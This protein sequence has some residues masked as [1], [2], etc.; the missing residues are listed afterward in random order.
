MNKYLTCTTTIRR[1][2]E[3]D[4]PAVLAIWEDGR[5]ALAEAGVDQWADGYPNEEILREDIAAGQSY[6]V[7]VSRTPAAVATIRPEADIDYEEIAEGTWLSQKKYCA[8]H[9]IATC[10][11]MKRMGL[12]SFIMENAAR[13]ARENGCVSLRI[14][15][16][17]DN[18][19]MQAFLERN[20]FV[21]CGRIRLH[22][23]GKMRVAFEKLL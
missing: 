5:R 21:R 19:T 3:A 23:S 18:R 2:T 14:D 7:L 13:I 22:R 12:A 11:S 9:R 17:D 1:T 10:A 15:T 16:H 20:G 8:V 4:I 6:L